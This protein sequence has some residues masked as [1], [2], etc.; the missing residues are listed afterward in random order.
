MLEYFLEGGNFDSAL[1]LVAA[2]LSMILFAVSLKSYLAGRRG[3]FLY[4]CV[5]FLVF[6]A[7]ETLVLANVLFFK[8]VALTSV[9]HSLNLIVLLAF[10]AGVVKR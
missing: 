1:H 2:S 6:A 3:K 8:E 5:A 4:V 9:S 7:S 10:F